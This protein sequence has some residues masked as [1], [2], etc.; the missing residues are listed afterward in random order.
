MNYTIEKKEA[1]DI[2]SFQENIKTENLMTALKNIQLS[3]SLQYKSLILN[4]ETMHVFEKEI[5]DLVRNMHQEMYT[6]N[7]SLA[8]VASKELV[9][10]DIDKELNIVPTLIEAIDIVSMEGLERELLSEDDF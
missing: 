4:M 6:N 5:F 9:N 10:F 8:L 3:N 1:F 7:C 2:I